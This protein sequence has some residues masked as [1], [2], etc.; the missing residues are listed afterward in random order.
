MKKYLP[1][2]KKIL[3][4]FSLSV[5]I[6]GVVIVL[7]A[8]NKHQQAVSFKNLQIDIDLHRQLFFVNHEEV[9]QVFKD[10]FPDSANRKNANI[11]IKLFEKQL[12]KNAFVEDAQIYSDMRG[13]IFAAI[14]Q[15]QPLLRIINNNGVSYYLD[16]N[17]EKLP[18]SNNFTPRVIVATGYIETNNNP[19]VDSSRLKQLFDIVKFIQNDKFLWALCE[20]IDVL[21]NG[22]MEIIPKTGK[23]RF[24]IGDTNELEAKFKRLKIFYTEVLKNDTVQYNNIINLKYHNQII[25]TKTM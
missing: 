4:L 10:L 1:I 12:E 13:N 15:K 3:L 24:I 8:A 14:V 25:C 21:Q 22:D 19:V 9:K 17:G 2:L 16:V 7:V 11:N 18:L 23:Y 5:A 6:V 20:Q